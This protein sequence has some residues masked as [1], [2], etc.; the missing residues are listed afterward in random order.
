MIGCAAVELVCSVNG[1]KSCIELLRS[2]Q[3][4]AVNDALVSIT[5]VITRMVN[6]TS[7]YVT[8][9]FNWCNTNP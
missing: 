1:D 6:S 5:F 4:N 3:L 7:E 2:P 9:V 8:T